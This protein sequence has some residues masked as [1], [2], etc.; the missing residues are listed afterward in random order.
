G[1]PVFLLPVDLIAFESVTVERRIAGE[2][3]EVV[4]PTDN[5]CA[6]LLHEHAHGKAVHESARCRLAQGLVA[7]T[8][9]PAKDDSSRLACSGRHL[10]QLRKSLSLCEG[11]LVGEG[12]VSTGRA[13]EPLVEAPSIFG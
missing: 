7:S 3:P 1:D 4:E 12:A 11:T 8:P 9:Q 6:R 5:T 2:Q 13:L 10:K